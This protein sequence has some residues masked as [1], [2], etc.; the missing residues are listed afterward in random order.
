METLTSW[1]ADLTPALKVYWALAIPFSLFFIGQM[2]LSLFGGGD[3]DD[4][5]DVDVEHDHGIGFQFITLNGIVGFFTIF[6]WTGVAGTHVGWGQWLTLIIASVSGL[7]MMVL[8]ASVIYMMLKMNASGTMKIN[9]A[10]GRSGEI[11]LSV[12]AARANTG[13]IQI[14]VGGLLRTLDAV[15]DDNEAIQ[16]GKQARVSGVLDNNILIVTSK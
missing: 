15:T 13:K 8:M 14:L 11:Y 5:P 12:P 7:L 10:I 6:S 2:V 3:H 1:W 4:V 16:T 9:E